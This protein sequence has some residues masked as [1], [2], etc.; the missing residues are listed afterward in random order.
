MA[1]T[2][3]RLR[4]E[5][6]RVKQIEK[7]CPRIMRGVYVRAQERADLARNC[8]AEHMPIIHSDIAQR[9]LNSMWEGS[10]TSCIENT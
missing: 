2:D 10:V 4:V 5:K 8:W 9:G 1:L 6:D 7:Q 3:I